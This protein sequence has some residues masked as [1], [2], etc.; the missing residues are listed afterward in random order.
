MLLKMLYDVVA[1]WLIRFKF[2]HYYNQE[3]EKATCIMSPEVGVIGSLLALV[4]WPLS[5]CS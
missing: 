3:K 4:Y 5:G 2:V 1:I